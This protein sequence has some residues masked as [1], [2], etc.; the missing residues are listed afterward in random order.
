MVLTG[1]R[2]SVRGTSVSRLA[3]AAGIVALAVDV[4]Y[5]AIIWAQEPHHHLG[6]VG[7]V[8]AAIAAAAVCALV[9][10]TR[11]KP[12]DRLPFLGAATGALLGLGYLGLFSVGLPLLVAAGFSVAAWVVTSD[13][14]GPAHPRER[15]V[16]VVLALAAPA[17]LVG[18]IAVT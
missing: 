11:P 4:L 12:A 17:V 14:A 15:I 18:G 1:E 3:I 8:A 16:A 5:L 2:S 6:R 9:G 10:A 13:A 7:F